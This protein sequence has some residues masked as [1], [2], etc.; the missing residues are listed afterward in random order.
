MS[1]NALREKLDELGKSVELIR[2]EIDRGPVRD[3]IA[4]IIK[5]VEDMPEKRT[6][7]A[8][9]EK[10]SEGMQ[11]TLPAWKKLEPK[12]TLKMYKSMCASALSQTEPESE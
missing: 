10:A 4:E 1:M 9:A 7:E 8:M 6:S 3:R 5:L 12:D 11:M 2:H